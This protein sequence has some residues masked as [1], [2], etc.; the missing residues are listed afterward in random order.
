MI[1]DTPC[2]LFV[3]LCCFFY[4][5]GIQVFFFLSFRPWIINLIKVPATSGCSCCS[6]FF[7]T[8]VPYGGQT[9][10]NFTSFSP[11]RDCTPRRRR[12]HSWRAVPRLSHR[13]FSASKK[14]RKPLPPVSLPLRPR[15][16]LHVTRVCVF[17]WLVASSH[18]RGA[19]RSSLIDHTAHS[20]IISYKSADD[21]NG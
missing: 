6:S 11:K 10:Q 4:V 13:Q 19:G 7:S 2:V 18:M 1:Y 5:P 8:A 12:R 21:Y 15:S 3:V 9:T 16:R 14:N 17:A 20:R